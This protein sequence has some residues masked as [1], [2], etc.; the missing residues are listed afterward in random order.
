MKTSLIHIV[1]LFVFSFFLSDSTYGQQGR[2]VNLKDRGYLLF[3]ET[4]AIF[5]PS[6]E[7]NDS[8]FMNR[9]RSDTGYKV[10]EHEYGLRL[11][12]IATE[13]KVVTNYLLNDSLISED[14]IISIIPVEIK[15][16]KAPSVLNWEITDLLFRYREKDYIFKYCTYSKRI[17]A[18]IIPIRKKDQISYKQ[19]T[20]VMPE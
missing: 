7:I 8:L 2:R 12:E 5:I 4:D 1:L 9:Y 20:K 6:K 15:Y 3:F 14:R 10:G 13:Y 11:K 16:L 18:S 19:K 17:I